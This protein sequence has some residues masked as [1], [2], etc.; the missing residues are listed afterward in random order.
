MVGQ[1]SRLPL[2]GMAS[3]TALR[4]RGRHPR[5][6]AHLLPRGA[7][8]ARAHR[9]RHLRVRRISVHTHALAHQVYLHL[10]VAAH[11]RPLLGHHRTPSV[12]GHAARRRADRPGLQ[13]VFRLVEQREPHLHARGLVRLPLYP[14]HRLVGRAG[15][16][17]HVLQQDRL[18]VHVATERRAGPGGWPARRG[19]GPKVPAPQ[20]GRGRNTPQKRHGR[21][22]KPQAAASRPEHGSSSE[23]KL[24]KQWNSSL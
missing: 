19:P 12:A 8:A 3:R 14:V 22:S 4:G 21:E 2:S 11:L 1:G 10:P 17:L 24:E 16:R 13:L 5:R 9:L 6:A 7:V 20:H 23:N 15:Q 18:A